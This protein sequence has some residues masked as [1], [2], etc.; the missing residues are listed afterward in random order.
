[1]AHLFWLSDEAWA[2]I[3]PHLPKGAARQA[4]G[5][6]PAGDLRHPAR[7]EDRLSLEGCAGGVWPTHYRLQPLHPVVLSRHLA[8]HVRAHGRSRTCARGVVL[9]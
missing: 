6:R 3:E 8:A 9:G 1:M 4:S 7:P 2:A 5:G